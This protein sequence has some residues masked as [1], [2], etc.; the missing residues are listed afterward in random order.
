MAAPKRQILTLSVLGIVFLILLFH[1]LAGRTDVPTPAFAGVVSPS[2][3]P[4]DSLATIEGVAQQ[5]TWRL[6]GPEQLRSML[7]TDWSP[8]LNNPFQMSPRILEAIG[9]DQPAKPND[10]AGRQDAKE[11][12]I[13]RPAFAVRSTFSVA[14]RW[15]AEIDDQL[16]RVGDIIRGF[17]IT[18]IRDDLVRVAPLDDSGDDP[19]QTGDQSGISPRCVI[20]VGSAATAYSGGR[21]VPLGD[22]AD[23]QAPT[24]AAGNI[25]EFELTVGDVQD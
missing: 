21:W 20:R 15:F 5:E 25:S 13:S 23:D 17:I 12:V 4:V 6:P 14:G 24:R 9:A 1:R 16:Y 19:R 11:P 22:P 10:P 8:P 2:I 3:N 18:D 7:V